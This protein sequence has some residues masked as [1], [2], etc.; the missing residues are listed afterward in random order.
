MPRLAGRVP[1]H[2]KSDMTIN[3]APKIRRITC[4]IR[5]AT[6]RALFLFQFGLLVKKLERHGAV[7][8]GA[9]GTQGGCD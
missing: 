4:N 8:R 1:E 3:P 2:E 5:S 9:A 7:G 6:F